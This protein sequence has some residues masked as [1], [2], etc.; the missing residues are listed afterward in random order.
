MGWLYVP[1]VEGLN[2]DSP[3]PSEM[4]TGLSVTLSAKP[5]QQQ[6][7]RRGLK[8]KPWMRL[9]S[10]MT[11]RPSTL[12]RGVESWI[13]SLAATRASRSARLASERARKILATYGRGSRTSSDPSGQNLLFS[14]TSE[15]TYLWDS[16][17]STR[18]F[19]TWVTQLR[20]DSLQRRSAA[21]R[22][23]VSGFSSWP[24]ATSG[25]AKGRSYQYDDHDKTKPRASL[26]GLSERWPTPDAGVSTR[27][28]KSQSEGAAVR[29][30]LAK[31]APQ[32]PTPNTPS[33][34]RSMKPEDV[35]NRGA[36][37]KGKRQVGLES[38]TKY[39]PTP[40]TISGGGESAERKKE[41]GR[42]N[43]GGGDLQSASQAWPT[44]GANDHKGTA[45]E[46]QRRGQLDEAAEQK[47]Q[48]GP[49]L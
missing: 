24:T 10:G 11:S 47:F 49:P 4:P 38:A 3:S 19:K 27:S 14:R 2:S 36:T 43:S 6:S 9:L 20:Q 48:S 46:G 5:M 40:R 33:G 23:G 45:K 32:W 35:A 30:L 39:W 29:P 34:G 13:L 21:R 41:L 42:E 26:T 1:G 16:A 28:N 18:S 44:P 15:D 12:A 37:E 22:I 17:K 25:E 8:T 31:M 7:W